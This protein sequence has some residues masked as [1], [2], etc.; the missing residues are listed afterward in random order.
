MKPHAAVISSVI[1]LGLGSVQY[2]AA[3]DNFQATVKASSEDASASQ[4]CQQAFQLAEEEALLQLDEQFIDQ[5]HIAR[6]IAQKETRT[7]GTNNQTICEFEGTWEGKE[8]TDAASLIGSEVSIDGQYTGSCL[9]ERNGDICWQRIIS[10]AADDLWQRLAVEH[11]SL[12]A[13]DLR[14][15]DFEG[16]QRD[17]YRDKRLEMTADGRF[18]F[19]VIDYDA[20]PKTTQITIQRKDEPV[21]VTPRPEP[22]VKPAEPVETKPAKEDN[23]DITL[24]YVWDGNDMAQHDDLAISSDR[25]GL[26]VWANN[27]IGFVAFKGQDTVGIAAD[28]E[29]VKNASGHYDT[30]GVGMGFRL[31]K[32]RGITLE[33][34]IYYVDTEPYQATVSP[35]CDSCTDRTFESQDYLQTTMN[36][37]TNSKGI[38]FGWMFTWKFLE[39]ETNIDALSSGF[40]IEALF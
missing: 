4:A 5:A 26:G 10:Q 39:N 37:K 18:Y 20:A 15:S 31:W 22:T 3:E 23:L 36:L 6:L 32:N 8:L 17:Q 24:F 14:Y 38:N 34:M 33:N 2:A 21:K 28:N 25:W 29:D 11:G 16:R 12:D 35:N 19:D 30:L 9:N 13:I 27:R 1:V 40:Y 7:V